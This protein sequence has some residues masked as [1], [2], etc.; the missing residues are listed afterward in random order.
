MIRLSRSNQ[1]GDRENKR[2]RLDQKI[3]SNHA[4]NSKSEEK[5]KNNAKDREQSM[6]ITHVN[7]SNNRT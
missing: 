3:E 7:N 6:S 4:N 1:P 5:K 2:K